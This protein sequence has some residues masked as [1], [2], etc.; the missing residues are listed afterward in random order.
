MKKILGCYKVINRN[1]LVLKRYERCTHTLPNVKAKVSM[2]VC[3]SL[4]IAF[5]FSGLASLKLMPVE[6]DKIQD[7]QPRSQAS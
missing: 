3:I 6:S 5:V 4:N 1:L 7:L 2:D